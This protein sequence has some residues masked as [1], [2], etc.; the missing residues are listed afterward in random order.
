MASSPIETSLFP[1]SLGGNFK[2]ASPRM[3][4]VEQAT[5]EQPTQDPARPAQEALQNPRIVWYLHYKIAGSTSGSWSS[6]RKPRAYDSVEHCEKA[7]RNAAA[8][9]SRNGLEPMCSAIVEPDLL[10]LGNSVEE[11][12][13]ISAATTKR[14]IIWV[15]IYRRDGIR[16]LRAMRGRSYSSQD[17]CESERA[18]IRAAAQ[19]LII[20][21]Q[22]KCIASKAD[23]E[24]A[25][26]RMA[27]QHSSPPQPT[28]CLAVPMHLSLSK[29]YMPPQKPHVVWYLNYAPI[30]GPI[31][32]QGES[33]NKNPRGYDSRVSCEQGMRDDM[34]D[35]ELYY[36]VPV[37]SATVEPDKLYLGDLWPNS[38]EKESANLAGHHLHWVLI[39]RQDP[40]HGKSARVG[41][42]YSSRRE[43]ERAVRRETSDRV[44]AFQP[45][46]CVAL[47]VRLTQGPPMD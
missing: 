38:L 20:E 29:F 23:C 4:Y 28:A 6:N 25:V 18:T 11:E 45:A 40:Q 42:S 43:C 12:P 7:T 8:Y 10:W 21:Q 5:H 15:L 3:Q 2:N 22:A 30:R 9:A 19:G 39:Y 14:Q 17:E 24:H 47:P 33:P 46:A 41:N 32:Y 44:T 31:D 26:E 27:A 34:A 16:G 37:C 13:G 36:L 1:N 35:P